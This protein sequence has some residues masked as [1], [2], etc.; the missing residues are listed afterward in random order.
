[1]CKNWVGNGMRIPLS[2]FDQLSDVYTLSFIFI[3]SVTVICYACLLYMYLWF[4]HSNCS[5][6]FLWILYKC[7]WSTFWHTLSFIYSYEMWMLNIILG[8]FLY[9]CL[10][11]DPNYF[12]VFRSNYRLE[13]ISKSASYEN[14]ALLQCYLRCSNEVLA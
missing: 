1:M 3:W 8:S 7:V 2:V 14:P 5:H 6:V 12:H 9:V 10:W 13:I 4:I 11:F